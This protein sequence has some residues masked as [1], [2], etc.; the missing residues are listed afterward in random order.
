MSEPLRIAVVA[1]GPTDGIVI[2]AA[3]RAIVTDQSF[4]LTQLQPEGSV[5]FGQTGGGWGGVYRWCKQSIRRGNGRLA[6]DRLV[7]DE[8]DVLVIHV[9]ADVAGQKYAD[10]AITPD[11]GDRELPC[12]YNCPPPAATT[13]ALRAVLLSWCAERQSPAK[14]V[15]CV[16]SKTT[17]TWVVASLFPGDTA[18]LGATPFECFA[19]PESRLGLQPKKKRIRKAQSDYRDRTAAIQHEWPRIAV[20]SELGE[21]YRFQHEILAVLANA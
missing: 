11:R 17:E 8:F 7:L 13:D 18:V 10:S 20:P 1:E 16:P 9:D 3:L 5:A 6:N 15:L 4:V 19:D 14:V 2:E 21:A 12:E